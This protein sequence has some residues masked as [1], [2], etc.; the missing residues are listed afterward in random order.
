MSPFQSKK[1][2]TVL[3]LTITCGVLAASFD[4]LFGNSFFPELTTLF[5]AIVIGYEFLS[6]YFKE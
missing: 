4:L 5:C 6:P 3:I 1:T 2:N